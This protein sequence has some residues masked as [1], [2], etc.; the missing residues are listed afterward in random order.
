[1]AAH[2]QNAGAQENELRSLTDKEVETVKDM[3]DAAIRHF[4]KHRAKEKRPFGPAMVYYGFIDEC[5]DRLNQATE[6]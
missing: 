4:R 2:R 5:Q 3:L 1:M 6:P